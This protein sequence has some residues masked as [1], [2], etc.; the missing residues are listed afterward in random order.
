MDFPLEFYIGE[1]K[2][3]GEKVVF[4]EE[5]YKKHLKKHLEISNP[6]YIEGKLRLTI[7]KPDEIY[8]SLITKDC[9]CFYKYHN[10]TDAKTERWIYFTKVVILIK[11]NPPHAIKSTFSENALNY[12]AIREIKLLWRR[13]NLKI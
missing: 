1:Y 13:S 11:K 7:E 4:T 9:H 12:R 8:E 2:N 6:Q 3:C 5:N 10:Y